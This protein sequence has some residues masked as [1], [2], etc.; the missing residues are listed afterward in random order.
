MTAYEHRSYETLEAFE[1]GVG[2]M[3]LDGWWPCKTVPLE[4]RMAIMFEPV[5]AVL[6]R[7]WHAGEAAG[8]ASLPPPA[9]DVTSLEMAIALGEMVA[10]GELSR[11]DFYHEIGPLRPRRRVR[12]TA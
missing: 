6:E 5:T 8:K 3:F 4:A 1:R 9:F 10:A 2:R 12:H 7:V 11:R